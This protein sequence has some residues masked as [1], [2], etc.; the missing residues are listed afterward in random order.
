MS[1]SD[2]D[3]DWSTDEDIEIPDSGPLNSVQ[4]DALRCRVLELE[5][6]KAALEEEVR[7]LIAQ[8]S[9]NNSNV[10]GAKGQ[11]SGKG[12]SKPGTVSGTTPKAN[13][14]VAGS[15]VSTPAAASAA[16]ST[17]KGNQT[18]QQSGSKSAAK[19]FGQVAKKP[20]GPRTL[21]PELIAKIASFF[22]PGRRRSLS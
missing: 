20:A 12:G 19:A 22:L 11:G 18:K 16:A 4:A 13:V 21:P 15:S 5:A 14:A 6:A 2:S 10:S 7:S 1:D 9:V 17:P 8:S 3:S